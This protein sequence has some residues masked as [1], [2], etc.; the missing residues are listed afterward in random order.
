MSS[1]AE[2][3]LEIFQASC[4][5]LRLPYTPSARTYLLHCTVHGGFPGL[6]EDVSR[7]HVEHCL[8]LW[9]DAVFDARRAMREMSLEL[10]LACTL[11]EPDLAGYGET[12]Q[13]AALIASAVQLVRYLWS[14]TWQGCNG[15]NS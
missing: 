11:L 4:V 7:L 9:R 15:K 2:Y 5:L 12:L 3:A 13:R 1:L 10:E 14:P 8:A 6:K